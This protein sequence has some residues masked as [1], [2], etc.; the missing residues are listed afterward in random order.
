MEYVYIRQEGDPATLKKY[1]QEMHDSGNEDLIAAY[2]RQA[3]IGITGVHSQAL[4]IMSLGHVFL[5][6][7]GISPVTMENNI[8]EMKGLIKATKNSFEFIGQKDK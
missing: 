6:R 3:E 2:N 5:K 7:F 4:Y 8:L 1:V